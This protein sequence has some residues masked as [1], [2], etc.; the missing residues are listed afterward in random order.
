MDRSTEAKFN[1][2]NVTL[3]EGL[4]TCRTVISDYRELLEAHA[5]QNDNGEQPDAIGDASDA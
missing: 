3:A 4:K 2:A 5:S 1:E